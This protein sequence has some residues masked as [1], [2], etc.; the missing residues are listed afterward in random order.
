MDS[1]ILEYQFHAT[2]LNSA[3]WCVQM[4]QRSWISLQQTVSLRKKLPSHFKA[5][6]VKLYSSMPSVY[7]IGDVGAR[8]VVIKNQVMKVT[9]LRV[10]RLHQTTTESDNGLKMC[11]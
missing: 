7:I 3:Q 1:E 6:L 10:G 9:M 5:M 8:S 11:A 2:S 4:M